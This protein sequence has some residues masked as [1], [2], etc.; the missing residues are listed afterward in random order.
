M[1]HRK[2]GRRL[3]RDA[4]HRKA[5]MKHLAVALFQHNAIETGVFKAK[6]LRVF[7]EPL[8]TL[9]KKDTIANRRHAFAKLRDESIVK[10]LFTEIGPHYAERPG[11]YTRILRLGNRV[12]DG[13]EMARIELVELGEYKAD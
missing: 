6:E 9:A 12:G 2:A 13:A 1:R 8:I 5:T 10:K 4:A 7:A 3:G 11:G